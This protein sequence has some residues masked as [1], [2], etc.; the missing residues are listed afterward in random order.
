MPIQTD[1]VA[2]QEWLARDPVHVV[3]ADGDTLISN[4]TVLTFSIEHAGKTYRVCGIS[5][6]MTYPEYRKF[7]YGRR[8]IA[9]ANKY[10]ESKGVDFGMLMT[11][12]DLHKFYKRNGWIVIP[13][14]TVLVGD[15]ANPRQED[16]NVLI[17][18]VSERGHQAV[19]VFANATVYVGTM[20]W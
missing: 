5:G 16:C 1:P 10:I 11:G 2:D 6:V 17:Y 15:K 3:I 19:N 4:A 20:L 8:V 18:P 7:G 13:K 12:P 9:G 14:P